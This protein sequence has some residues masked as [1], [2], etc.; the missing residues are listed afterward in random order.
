V[1]MERGFSC[2]ASEPRKPMEDSRRASCRMRC[3]VGIDQCV[4]VYAP[5]LAVREAKVASEP[6]A[7]IGFLCRQDLEIA[8]SG[9]KL[10]V[11]AVAPCGT[12]FSLSCF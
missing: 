4:R 6:E 8:R 12:A 5:G 7:L 10:S 11:V 3:V 2:G 1:M 9:L